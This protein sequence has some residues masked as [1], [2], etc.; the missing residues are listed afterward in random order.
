M[1]SRII[2]IINAKHVKPT[3][4]RARFA[5]VHVPGPPFV[6]TEST[7]FKPLRS[8]C[9]VADELRVNICRN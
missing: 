4:T 8:D 2:G 1:N 3:K 5:Y 9:N 6:S 7:H